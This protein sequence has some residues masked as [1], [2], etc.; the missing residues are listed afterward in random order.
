MKIARY[1]SNLLFEYECIVIPGFGGFI[2]KEIPAQIHPVQNHFIPPTKDVVFNVHLKANDG[3]L[4]NHIARSEKITYSEA[5]KHVEAFVAQCKEALENGRQIRFRKIGMIFLNKDGY[6]E[7]VIDKTQNYRADS[8][9]LK[10]FISPPIKRSPGGQSLHKQVSKDRKP[11]EVSKKE[12]ASQKVKPRSDQPRYLRVN[13]SAV[14]ITG[15]LVAFFIFR[16]TTLKEYYNNYSSLIPF[17]YSNPNQYL[18]D[19]YEELKVDKLFGISDKL[20]L[21]NEINPTSEDK[22]TD[23]AD[24]YPAEEPE[25]K[26]STESNLNSTKKPLEASEIVLT[27]PVIIESDKPIVMNEAIS[28]PKYYIIAGSFKTIANADRLVLQLKQKGYNA[29]VVGKNKSNNYRVYFNS[30]AS[31]A[32]TNEQLAIV[33][34]NEIADAWILKK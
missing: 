2:T 25:V 3:L 27:N 31:L 16:F 14:I 7:F 34:R 15:L 30:Y 29:D 4:I 13:I 22:S 19:N 24:D 26:T 9:G 17:F 11:K 1:I 12:Q 20:N 5:K 23:I 21:S 33:R 18:I 28:S 32:E 10:S 6:K 8:F